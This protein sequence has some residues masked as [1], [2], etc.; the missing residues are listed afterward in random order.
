MKC[1]YLASPRFFTRFLYVALLWLE[2]LR[3]DEFLRSASDPDRKLR[4]MLVNISPIESV[5]LMKVSRKSCR[6]DVGLMRSATAEDAIVP[7]MT[8]LRTCQTLL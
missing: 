4:V 1:S 6:A 5:A 8:I 2:A 7:M 3:K